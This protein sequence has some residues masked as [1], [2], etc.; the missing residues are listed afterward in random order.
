MKN[1]KALTY[2]R[3]VATC[4]A[5]LQGL[6]RYAPLELLRCSI[7]NTIASF[8]RIALRPRF[9]APLQPCAVTA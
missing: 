4:I 7:I 5:P 8:T 9:L 3:D 6:H 1:P 2:A